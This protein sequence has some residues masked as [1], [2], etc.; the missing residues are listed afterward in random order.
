MKR[1]AQY[2]IDLVLIALGFLVAYFFRFS[3]LFPLEKGIPQLAKYLIALPLTLMVFS[4]TFA[5]LGLYKRR[6][7]IISMDIIGEILLGSG[8]GTLVLMSVS[9]LY[10]EFSYSRLVAVFVFTFAVLFLILYRVIA[11]AV[12]RYQFRKGRLGNKVAM[13]G[14]TKL[15][16]ILANNMRAHPELGY[17]LIEIFSDEPI[18]EYAELVPTGTMNDALKAIEAHAI[19]EVY[20][21]ASI[22]RK[23]LLELIIQAEANDVAVRMIPDFLEIFTSRFQPELALGLPLLSLRKFPLTRTNKAV[24]RVFDLMLSVPLFLIL[25]P[26]MLLIGL[27]VKITSPGPILY[28][29]VRLGQ[30]GKSFKLFKFRSMR[31]DAEKATGP[32]WAKPND[33]RV[34]GFGRIIRRTSLDELPQIWNIIRGDMSWVGP[35]PERPVFVEQF[36]SEI[37]RYMERL[38]VKSGVTGWAQVNGLRGNTS[39]ED[40]LDYDLYYIENWSLWFDIKIILRTFL[41]VFKGD[42][43]Y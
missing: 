10:R 27:V 36:S 15:S 30:D 24:K 20:L 7:Q 37:P 42:G 23:L 39:V 2:L 32:I 40:R 28:R 34:T 21:T 9:F 11:R 31:Q 35:R 25:L 13:I 17:R 3:G 14:I 29:Q 38:R 22:P 16:R 8:I 33:D 5:S 43:A 18:S 19:D 12:L 1:F 26:L 41:A 6:D 4:L